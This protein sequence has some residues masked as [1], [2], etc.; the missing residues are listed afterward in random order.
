MQC[1]SLFKKWVEDKSVAERALKIW[2]PFKKIMK[3]CEG[4]SKLK[5]PG[6]K[7]Y[8]CLKTHCIDPLVPSKGM[9][10]NMGPLLAKN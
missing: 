10:K 2:D 6:N 4:L 5:Q 1:V 7:S 8:R 9:F 3:Y